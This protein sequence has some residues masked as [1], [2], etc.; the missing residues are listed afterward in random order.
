MEIPELVVRLEGHLKQAFL[1]NH[2]GV[3]RNLVQLMEKM[4]WNLDLVLIQLLDNRFNV[5]Q[6]SLWITQQYIFKKNIVNP[7]YLWHYPHAWKINL[8]WW[9][10][11]DKIHISHGYLLNRYA[12]NFIKILA[13]FSTFMFFN[14]S[15][16]AASPRTPSQALPK[17]F[18]AS[19]RG[20]FMR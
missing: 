8:D 7:V 10:M 2:K 5:V 18:K 17:I 13:C 20:I 3:A 14:E 6:N 1:L 11:V 4:S 15:A 16:E 19:L 12:I 9:L